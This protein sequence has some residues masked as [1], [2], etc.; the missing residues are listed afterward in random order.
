V[1]FDFLLEYLW[2]A[3]ES[4]EAIRQAATKEATGTRR[5]HTIAWAPAPPL[6]AA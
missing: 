6:I 1:S 2:S 4:G 3:G 5:A